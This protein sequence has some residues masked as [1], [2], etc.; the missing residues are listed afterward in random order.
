L[1]VLLFSIS[2]AED[3]V[4]LTTSNFQDFI[5]KHER[6]LVEFYAPWC[7][8][9]K[10][11]A[12]EYEKA[13]TSLKTKNSKTMLAKV[14]ATEEKELASKYD[15]KGFPTLKYFNGDVEHPSEYTGGRTES[16]IVSWLSK[17]ESPALSTIDN[18]ESYRD[19]LTRDNVILIGFFSKDSSH[20]QMLKDIGE[21]SREFALTLLVNNEK[22]AKDVN[23]RWNSLRLVV[24]IDGKKTE[25]DYTGS[26]SAEDILNWI[27]SERFPLV[28]EIGPENYKDYVDRGLPLVWIAINPDDNESKDQIINS[29]QTSAKNNKGKLS[30]VTI[31]AKKFA[32]HINNLGI[33][34]I[35]GLMLNDGNDK[36]RYTGGINEQEINQFFEN[37]SQ[38]KLEKYLKSQAIPE[39]NDENVY[40]LVGSQFHEVI[41]KNKDV[42]VEFYAPWCGHCK[43]LAPEYEKLGDAFEDVQ[44]V[45][46]AKIDATE[47]DTPE[48]IRGFP[49]LVFYP[50]GKHDGVKYQG[51]RTADA[52]IEWVKSQATVD[53]TAV[54]TE[55]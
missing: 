5:Q 54:K 40:V 16:T 36:Y 44:D 39:S 4:T 33:T 13:A 38:G 9:C 2:L 26:L 20:V 21:N 14:D 35:P 30:F 25:V 19:Y 55:L 28:A 50:K 23:A 37:Y 42:F 32:Q 31:D 53:T 15:V 45:I 11:L 43:K 52:M 12:P 17:R 29:V 41:G 3:V 51:D 8:H 27:N 6:V 1:L 46:I 24:N 48:D 34:D 22:V 47:N 18:I 49:T 10:A 7:G